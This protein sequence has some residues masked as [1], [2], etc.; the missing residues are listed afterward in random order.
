MPALGNALGLP[1]QRR[2]ASF[3]GALDAYTTNMDAAWS[4]SRR[5]LT[6]YSG[7]LIRVRR[8]SDNNEQDI[9]YSAATG[10]LDTASLL[11]FVGAGNGFV[12]KV[13][14][15]SGGSTKDFVQTTAAA[16][17][18]IVNAGSLVTAGT[19]NRATAEVV[20]ASTQFMATASFTTVAAS[21]LTMSGFFRIVSS[22][23]SGRIFGA[24]EA[25]SAD[26]AP[27]GG[28]LPVY[29]ASPGLSSYNNTNRASLTVTMPQNLSVSSL[30]IS[31][32][33]TLRIAGSSNTSSFIPTAASLN[34]YLLFCFNTTGGSSHAGDMF[35]E[36]CV[37]TANRDSD[38]TA[39]L[40]ERNTFYGAP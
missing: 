1:F 12:T 27:T 29:A 18:R 5:L 7:S 34:H 15:Q 25:G 16:Q 26:A 32:G 13:Y 19:N 38:Q 4:V 6:S 3:V 22:S 35:G 36:N 33:H 2:G 40:A 9:G 30:C 24:C 23:P 20:T 28:W 37:W 17:M 39:I 11:S 14:A 31:T 10:L 8:S 21:S